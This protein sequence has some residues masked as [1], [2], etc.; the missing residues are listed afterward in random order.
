[1]IGILRLRIDDFLLQKKVD[2]RLLNMLARGF[3]I[4]T[5]ERQEDKLKPRTKV[6][7]RLSKG[8][9]K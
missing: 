7:G 1:M 6:E 8:E 5:G 9:H 4:L 3:S 2:W